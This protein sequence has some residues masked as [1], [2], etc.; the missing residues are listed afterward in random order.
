MIYLV[1]L[2]EAKDK[3]LLVSVI[4]LRLRPALVKL[5]ILY[6][7]TK[8]ILL[9]KKLY[10]S[11]SKHAGI[12]STTVT[13][14]VEQQLEEIRTSTLPQ[15]TYLDVLNNEGETARAE[16]FK[17]TFD[18]IKSVLIVG[19]LLYIFLGFRNSLVA[20]IS[21]PLVLLAV[22]GLGLMADQ[23]VNRITLF[24]LIL[25]LGLLVDDAIVVVENIARYFRLHPN[26][27]NKIHLIVQSVNEVGGA[28]SLSTLTTAL[29]FLPMAFVTGMM[30]PY[31]G[32]IPF[33]VPAALLVSLLLSVTINP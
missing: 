30:G 14:A 19:I 15:N 28:L 26:E 22:F 4:S 31:M 29:A 27:P 23:T 3:A 10:I 9:A 5:L 7:C 18:L 17:L 1:L 20:S 24:A 16:I 21:I 33:F 6:G 32:P 25:S 12:N 11:P 13:D 2:S 8:R